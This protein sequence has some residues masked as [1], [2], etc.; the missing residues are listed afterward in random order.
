[1]PHCDKFVYGVLFFSLPLSPQVM[2]EIAQEETT[3]GDMDW[4]IKKLNS[5]MEMLSDE[6]LKRRMK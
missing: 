6:R 4:A 1:M 2:K 3:R 5:N